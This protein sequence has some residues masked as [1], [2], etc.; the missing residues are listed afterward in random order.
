[1]RLL[2]VQPDSGAVCLPHLR[3]AL[4]GLADKGYAFSRLAG[5]L[6]I[7]WFAYLLGSSGFAITKTLIGCVCALIALAG[8][9]AAVLGRR[10]ILQELRQNWKH[11][12][13]IELL[14]LGAFLF[15]LWV[16]CNNPD[17][18][19]PYK[20]G[21]KPMDFSYFNAVIKAP[22]SRRMTHGTQADISITITTV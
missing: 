17:L 15:F 13:V 1:M 9:L 19:H 3:L 22:L 8:A 2:P 12:L 14:A 7:A 11:Y 16:R 18:W 20:G 10:A 21:E 6:L 4:P 5:F